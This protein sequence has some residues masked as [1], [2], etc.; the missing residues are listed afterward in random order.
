MRY[1]LKS[2]IPLC[3]IA[4]TGCNTSTLFQTSEKSTPVA[5][6]SNEIVEFNLQT[7]I[8]KINTVRRK[9]FLR[10]IQLDTR[11]L[12]AA[13][14]HANLMGREG[15]YG[16]ELGPSTKFKRRI[17]RAGFNN[18]AGENLGVG[19]RSIDA[20]IQGWLDSPGHRKILLKPNYT[21]GGVAYARNTSGKSPRLNHFWVLIVGQEG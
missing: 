4:L 6:L 5:P 9:H 15:K 19:Y 2:F 21:L 12:N 17:N 18:S 13:Q 11:L 3:C 10:P 20:A 7:S 1:L 16:H 8:E 14:T